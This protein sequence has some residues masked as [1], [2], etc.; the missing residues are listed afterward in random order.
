MF[1]PLP[2]SIWRCIGRLVSPFKEHRERPPGRPR[3]QR[4]IYR[5]TIFS[6]Q[7][8]IIIGAARSGTKML[9][10]ILAQLPG[11]GTWPC[12]EI[13]GI[14]RY[15]NRRE[16][17]D[18]F[19]PELATKSVRAFICRAFGRLAQERV[20]AH[21]VEKTCANSLRVGFVNR[22]LP[23]AYFVHIV[24]DGRDVVA[25]AQRRWR[26]RPDWRYV[27]RKARFVPAVDFPYYATRYL[28]NQTV[29]LTSRQ[30]RLAFWGPRFAGMD[31]ALRQ[32][33]L[34]EVCALQ[35][36]RSVGRAD[37][38]FARIEPERVYS[39]GYETFVTRP[40]VELQRLGAF[41]KT[42]ISEALA[43]KV[44]QGVTAGRIGRWHTELDPKTLSAVALLLQETLK[45]HGYQ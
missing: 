29:R 1:A 26:A 39:L 7:P 4:E 45:R 16:P 5:E 11:F 22:V 43:R 19:E 2:A 42:P 38:D 41:L 6:C 17:T 37:G 24:R 15:G 28:W 25:S 30:Q 36:Q 12:D 20:L 3:R 23:Q 33:S 35:W 32:Y 18:E 34:A 27:L 44:T 13:N 21:V 10:D 8:V 40:D 9:R 14:W 31:Q